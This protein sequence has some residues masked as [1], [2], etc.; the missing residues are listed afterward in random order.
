[1]EDNRARRRKRFGKYSNFTIDIATNDAYSIFTM[2]GLG[3]DRTVDYE[4]SRVHR[5]RAR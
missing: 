4:A 5:L 1:M 3:R 2:V